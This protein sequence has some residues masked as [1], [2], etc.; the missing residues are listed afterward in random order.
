MK[1]ILFTFILIILL[2]D[3][4][5]KEKLDNIEQ[6]TFKSF[7]GVNHLKYEIRTGHNSKHENINSK[8]RKLSTEFTPIRIF[9]DTTFLDIQAQNMPDMV[10]NIPKIKRALNKSIEGMSQLLEVKQSVENIYKDLN[11]TIIN[12]FNISQ[13]D[14][15]LNNPKEMSENYDYILLVR[16]QVETDG[17]PSNVQAA[18][19]PIL[20]EE[21]DNRPIAG[22]MIVSNSPTFFLKKN[23]E[24]YFSNVFIHELTHGLGFIYTSYEYYPGGLEQTL[25]SKIDE[26]GINHTYVKTPKVIEFAKKYFG[27]N[28]IEGVEL[29]NQGTE[30]S[31]LS[32]WEAK[33]L[34]GEYMTS[35]MYQDELAISEITLAFLE[36]SNWY[37]ANYYT[38][39]LMRFG[40]NKGCNF[41]TKHCLS[42]TQTEFNNEYFSLDLKD[43]SSCTTGRQS[44]AYNILNYYPSL[45]P[46][47][48]YKLVPT[49][50]EGGYTYYVGG[51]M[52]SADYC[53]V[54]F[55][56]EKEYEESYFVGNC[57]NGNG[58]Y[59]S[60][61]YY[62]NKITGNY[63]IH[64][65]SELPI[66][67]GEKYSEN[68]FCMMSN[69]VPIGKYEIFGTILHPMC[70][71]SYCSSS[72]LTILV[73]D[74]Y[75]V[76]PKQ[77]GNVQVAGY[78]GILHCPDYNLI[79]TGTVMCNELFDCIEKKSEYKETTFSYDYIPLT[80]QRY[81][82]IASVNTFMA[83]ETSE[84][85]V[86][87]K[88]C[89]Q[90]MEN[91]KCKLCLNGYNLIGI[92]E[93]DDQPI[94]CNNA[95]N[96]NKG[97]YI[98]DNIYY[99]CHN[100]CETCSK[101]PISNNQMNCDTCK[102]GFHLESGNCILDKKEEEKENDN[103]N[104]LYLYLIIGFVSIIIIIVIIIIFLVIRKRRLSNDGE[105]YN[106]LDNKNEMNKLY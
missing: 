88:Y 10:E 73:Y 9:I 53:P 19:M 8:T 37:K 30:G 54:S 25:F 36:D 52:Y 76:C 46:E 58:N 106:S 51:Y 11:S 65:N 99:P 70:F 38:G 80:T 69:L 43:F 7:C 29:E 85:G 33:I 49:Y 61:L 57:K 26:N 15:R 40:K 35:E 59:G 68:S 86:C 96:I 32:H 104:S 79:C 63:E 28:T 78:N 23:V 93:N 13:W 42:Y 75:V 77:G 66:E 20:T 105:V 5:T 55:H 62:Q 89:I 24:H 14:E 74:Q 48:F 83:Y 44:R 87:P 92:K 84:D 67:L 60:N 71:P 6:K 82:D 41:I 45:Y 56:I 103:G 39:G 34:L 22:L 16:F 94:I 21:Y 81:V 95:I 98:K 17:F 50:T 4:S 101:G 3:I 1:N 100:D 97:Y 102:N 18:A 72:S 31:A 27:C 12:K 64:K 2:Y 90:C 91:K 47:G